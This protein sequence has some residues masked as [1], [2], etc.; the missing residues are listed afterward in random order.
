MRHRRYRVVTTAIGLTSNEDTLIDDPK[1]FRDVTWECLLNDYYEFLPVADD[2]PLD[3]ELLIYDCERPALEITLQDSLAI[4]AGPI[5]VLERQAKDRRFALLGTQGYLYRF[6]L[7]ILERSKGIYSFHSNALYDEASNTLV[8]SM[9]GAGAGKTPV[10]LS[11]IERGWKVFSTE[12][13]HATIEG[14]QCVFYKGGIYDNVRVGNLTE[15]FPA[16]QAQL[17]VPLP[18]VSDVWATK[19]CMDL[20]AAEAKPDRLVNPNVRILFPRIEAGWDQPILSPVTTRASLQKA[21]YDNA[22][23]KVGTSFLL[24][25]SVP[26][27]GFDSPELARKRFEAMGRLLD[28]MQLER[29]EALLSSAR[30]CRELF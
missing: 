22:S 21:L 24:Y 10:L 19:V 5:R 13:T 25:E 26:V 2:T 3:G 27:S 28:T 29:A 18:Q 12:L 8:I 17:G 20:S 16:V 14:G 15:D 6:V 1:Y 7:Y 4:I 9:G 11:G 23:E 30:G